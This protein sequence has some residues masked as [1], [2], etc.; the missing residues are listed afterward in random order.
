MRTVRLGRTGLEVS[1]VG[2]GGIP[3]TRPAEEDAVKL[4]QRALELG[5]SFIDTAIGYR[6]SE[7]RIARAV[8]ASGVRRDQ[9]ILAT[10]GGTAQHIAWS[11][12]RLGTDYLDLWQF[13]GINSFERL[14]E[15]LGPGGALEE[16]EQARQAGKIRHI[17]FSSHSLRVAREGVASGR[18][19][20]VQFPLNF[21][22]AEAAEE[23]VPLARAHDVGFIA[24]KPL[25][26]GRIRDASLAIKYLLQFDEVVP[27]PGVE[28]VE[29]IEEIVNIVDS[30]SWEL[31]AAERQA[32]EAIRA[33]V[34]T[35]FC[36]QCEYC[37][38]CP[39]GVHIPGVM[40]LPILWELWPA[41]WFLSWRYV[42]HAVESARECLQCGECETKCPYQLPIRE[43]LVEN[44][45]FYERVAGHPTQGDSPR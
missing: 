6:D 7:V 8:A 13:H 25:A 41:D 15:V 2:I 1:R 18:F 10:K 30:G 4:V 12:Q 5:V 45:A 35:R 34:G 17:G 44:I 38:P 31:T 42:N 3:L 29:E 22:S 28:R 27:D 33:R 40:Y 37:L 24:M 36:R 11:L 20:T 21:I 23:L 16:G 39:Q 14:A 26:G 9:V 32:M 43:M 19:D